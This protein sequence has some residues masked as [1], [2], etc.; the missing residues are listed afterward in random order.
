MTRVNWLYS[1]AFLLLFGGFNLL[2]P[3]KTQAKIDTYILQIELTPS[4][5][6]TDRTQIK[7]RKCLEGYALTVQNLTPYM[8]VQKDCQTNKTLYLAPVQTRIVAHLIPDESTRKHIWQQVGG[9]LSMNASQYFRM[10]TTLAEKLK[11]PPEITDTR[12]HQV[13][14]QTFVNELL[15]LNPSMPE[16]SVVLGCS[17]EGGRRARA[18]LT[19]LNVCYHSNN[20]Y[21]ACPETIT[22]NCPNQFWLK[23]AY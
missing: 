7:K 5:C 19:S 6:A 8:V 18:L 20:R 1:Y 3:Q 16:Q 17:A 10:M 13:N 23:G 22:T 4:V 12:S 15:K 21:K 9:C 11:V 14:H 2:L